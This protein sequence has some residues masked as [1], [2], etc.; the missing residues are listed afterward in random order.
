MLID[1]GLYNVFHF[2]CFGLVTQSKGFLR[3][4]YFL[5]AWGLNYQGF[6][7]DFSHFFRGAFLLR[8]EGEGVFC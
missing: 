1:Y 4:G 6:R 7:N 8:G 5:L 3:G 2:L